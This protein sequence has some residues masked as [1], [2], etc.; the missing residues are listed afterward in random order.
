M[1]TLYALEVL[2]AVA[3]YC[4]PSIHEEISNNSMFT[5]V[6][7]RNTND[8][9]IREKILQLIYEWSITFQYSIG[10]YGLEVR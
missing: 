7:V 4:G 3:K 9:Q 5:V 10:Y 1:R 8:D 6:L 2:E